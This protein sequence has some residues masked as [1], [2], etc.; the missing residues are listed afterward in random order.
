MVN[1]HCELWNIKYRQGIKNVDFEWCFCS[2]FTG[3]LSSVL[4]KKLGELGK[5]PS[6]KLL[7]SK[8]VN[9]TRNTRVHWCKVDFP[10]FSVTLDRISAHS[11]FFF[12][13]K[14]L[15]KSLLTVRKFVLATFWLLAHDFNYWPQ[16]IH[17]CCSWWKDR[18][19]KATLTHEDRELVLEI[20]LYFAHTDLLIIT[21]P[22][23]TRWRKKTWIYETLIYSI[24]NIY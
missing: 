4:Q 16:S 3:V 17:C 10:K 14:T 13:L 22:L 8:I 15:L 5:T 1:I 20:L 21:K 2:Y 11:P 12:G 7:L 23:Y 19:T 18:L 6:L 24:L 9:C